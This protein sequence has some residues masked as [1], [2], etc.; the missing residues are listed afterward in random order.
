MKASVGFLPMQGA[1]QTS[2]IQ[3]ERSV[4]E[5]EVALAD[6][7]QILASDVCVADGT[8]RQI[9]DPVAVVA[10]F[11]EQLCHAALRPILAHDG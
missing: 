5:R 3:K 9:Q 11:G 8:G 4:G 10:D 2:W 1:Q 6:G 7:A